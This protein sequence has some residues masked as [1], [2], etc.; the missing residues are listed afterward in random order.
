MLRKVG[1]DLGTTN[2][3][4]YCWSGGPNLVMLDGIGIMPSALYVGEKGERLVGKKAITKGCVHPERLITSSKTE[5]TTDKV[6]PDMDREKYA[7]KE[8]ISPED[9]ATEILKKVRDEMI[10]LGLAQDGDD[11]VA[12]VT[13]PANFSSFAVNRT[14]SAVKRAGFHLYGEMLTEP[15]AAASQCFNLADQS[16]VFV[17]DFGGG[18]LDLTLLKR[19]GDYF[20]RIGTPTG[21]DCLGGDNFDKKLADFI[22]NQIYNDIEVDMRSQSAS[23]MDIDTY[24]RLYSA[25]MDNARTCKENLSSVTT[26]KVHL[27]IPVKSGEK[28]KYRD[29][30]CFITKEMFEED[31]CKN[32]FEE[33]R[34]C[35]TK[36][37]NEN[38]LNGA[39]S[40]SF[41]NCV[42]VGGSAYIPKVKKIVEE[43]IGIT[44]MI[45]ADPMK[46]VALGALWK[47]TTAPRKQTEVFLDNT[48]VTTTTGEKEVLTVNIINNTREEMG[49][50]EI[51]ASLNGK[52]VNISTAEGA[53][54]DDDLGY[55]RT[56]GSFVLNPTQAENIVIKLPVPSDISGECKYVV[57]VRKNTMDLETGKTKE[58]VITA[59]KT[60]TKNAQY[61]IMMSITSD[62]PENAA[63]IKEKYA[64]V[65]IINSAGTDMCD[66]VLSFFINGN[67]Y[68]L[69][70]YSMLNTDVPGSINLETGKFVFS[71]TTRYSNKIMIKLPQNMEHLEFQ[72]YI[73]MGDNSFF[74]KKQLDFSAPT[75]NGLMSVP[76]T[77]SH[78]VGVFLLEEGTD[79]SYYSPIFK[80][81]DKVLPSTTF[82]D[83]YITERLGK[84][85]YTLEIYE[86]PD[87]VSDEEATKENCR[88]AMR[89]T[90][91]DY[92]PD[93]TI[94]IT[95]TLGGAK[96]IYIDIYNI[97]QNKNCS[98]KKE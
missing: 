43:V 5:L 90:Y 4:A 91:L 22:I 45:A 97:T 9:V 2:T 80:R 70:E 20:R 27:R 41:K 81:G 55:T 11:I 30:N 77:L 1:I 52:A 10:N 50:S 68:K 60:L 28:T 71:S 16:V 85:P 34:A 67:D 82:V 51:R 44:P 89:Y 65:E 63:G 25:I 42:L 56:D 78:D 95:Y 79:N 74:E 84:P 15:E 14:I 88:L 47:V 32:E 46:C 6:Y 37:Y 26:V 3:V 59:E 53:Y 94:E 48:Y 57:S 12:L 39:I 18:T 62:S 69:E 72:A 92:T 49:G 17:C 54:Y 7:F 66:S 87:T 98:L 58:E 8:K 24:R 23:G 29:F 83:T 13:V 76:T 19:D 96:N 61:G 93:D 86:K 35:V 64:V 40:E 73:K 31:I 38:K 33:F 75:V 21:N 36:F